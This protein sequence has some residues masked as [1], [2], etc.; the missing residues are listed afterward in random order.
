METIEIK[1]SDEIRIG[2]VITSGNKLYVIQSYIKM[3]E[4]NLFFV[5]LLYTSE[6][7][8]VTTPTRKTSV[9]DTDL[10]TEFL[11]VLI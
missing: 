10:L 7:N 3:Y 2:D 4:W 9:R 11:K 5:N 1:S 6:Y 8:G